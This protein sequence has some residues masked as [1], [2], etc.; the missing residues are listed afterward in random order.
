MDGEFFA[1]TPFAVRVCAETESGLG[2]GKSLLKS[3]R[4]DTIWPLAK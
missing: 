1:N 3:L 4:K 2:N